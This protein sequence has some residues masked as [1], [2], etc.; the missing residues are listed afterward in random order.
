MFFC[1]ADALAVKAVDL[2]ELY[3]FLQLHVARSWFETG[4]ARIGVGR[5]YGDGYLGA[6]R[7]CWY[8][9]RFKIILRGN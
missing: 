7:L 8:S 3:N 1:F 4:Y 5:A 9:R 2:S 6:H